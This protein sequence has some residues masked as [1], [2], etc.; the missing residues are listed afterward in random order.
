MVKAFRRCVLLTSIDAGAMAGDLG[1]RLLLL[2]LEPIDPAKRQE[3]GELE[4]RRA[5]AAPRLLGA[6]LT[7][8]ARTLAKMP[9]VKMPAE[10]PRLADFCRV[11]AALD[12]AAPEVTGRRALAAYLEQAERIA[13]DVVQ[14]D[15]VAAA[16]L[17][18]MEWR[19]EWSGT[20]AE[21]LAVLHPRDK[22]GDPVRPPRGWP[23]TPQKLGSAIRRTAPA[24]LALGIA[25]DLVKSGD[26]L[27]T[28]RKVAE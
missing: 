13:D 16:V 3:L 9:T 5:A 23:D 21:L 10:L 7:T 18:F 4:H 8:T 28:F 15:P 14:A 19:P 20:A 2:D 27:H 1:S 12:E 6:L 22:W 26:R 25:H 17:T 11:A 24:L